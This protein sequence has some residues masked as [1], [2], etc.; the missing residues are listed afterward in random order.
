MKKCLAS[1]LLAIGLILNVQAQ[2]R[3]PND[4][5]TTVRAVPDNGSTA[6]LLGVGLVALALASRRRLAAR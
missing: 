4:P 1:A 6:V 5:T 3:V 2:Q